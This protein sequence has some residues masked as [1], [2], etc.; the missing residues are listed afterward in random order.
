MIKSG[1][2]V[3]FSNLQGCTLYIR[4]ARTAFPILVHLRSTLRQQPR[5]VITGIK[6]WRAMYVLVSTLHWI[7]QEHSPSGLHRAINTPTIA[8]LPRMSISIM[9]SGETLAAVH[10][11]LAFN[12]FVLNRTLL[13]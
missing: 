9:L 1:Y 8:N 13:Y 2:S 5:E 4:A 6:R 3:V 12:L 11:S 10:G 7:V